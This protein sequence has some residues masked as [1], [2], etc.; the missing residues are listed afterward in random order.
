MNQ[1][2]LRRI[3]YLALPIIGGMASQNILNLV[4]TYM[5]GRYGNAAL[6]AVGIGGFAN[7]MAMAVILGISSGVQATAARRKG[8]ERFEVMAYPLNA[9]LLIAVV[10]GSLLTVAYWFAIPHVYHL[11]NEDPAV[12]EAGVPYLQFRVLAIAFV[13]MNFSFRGFWNGID[14]SWLYMMTLI[15]MHTSNIFLNWVLIFGNLGAP[16]MGAPGAGLATTISTVIGCAIYF[17]MGFV[18]AKP[19]G[20]LESLPS[21]DTIVR[22]VRL[23]LPNSIQQFAFAAGFTVLYR[24][25]GEVGTK[26]VAAAN[27]LINIMLVAI[28]P[29]IALG[30]SAATLVGQALGRK[31]P[32]DARRWGWDVVKVGMVGLGLLG[33]PMLLMPNVL[34]SFFIKDPATVQIAHFPMQFVGMTIAFEGIG[35]ILMNALL[36]AGAAKRVMMVSILS[37]WVVFLPLAY[38]IGPHMGFGLLGIWLCQGGYRLLQSVIFGFMWQYGDWANIKV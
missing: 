21:R 8:E 35:L 19:F 31:Q 30:L 34:L 33:L 24:I 16:E 20:F 6:A 26:E 2:R 7:F 37:Q 13:G 11:L 29:G 3:A 27:V 36:G 1:S 22:L 12:A 32:Q 14:K 17:G 38:W 15:V 10:A 25:I 23:S 28:L 18:H 9:G 5:V 4:D